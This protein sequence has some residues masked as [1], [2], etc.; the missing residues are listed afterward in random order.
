M[1]RTSTKV[2]TIKFNLLY[3]YAINV[4]EKTTTQVVDCKEIDEELHTFNYILHVKIE[5]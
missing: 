4:L 1:Y 2:E 5:N 3:S